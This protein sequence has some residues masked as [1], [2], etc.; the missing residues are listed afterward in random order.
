MRKPC[1]GPEEKVRLSM[2]IGMC[3]LHPQ[4]LVFGQVWA[5]H[6]LGSDEKALQSMFLLG[7]QDKSRK[8]GSL[9]AGSCC[10]TPV[11]SRSMF[12]QE[13]ALQTERPGTR[14]Q[15]CWGQGQEVK[16]AGFGTAQMNLLAGVLGQEGASLSRFWWDRSIVLVSIWAWEDTESPSKYQ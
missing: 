16:G 6:Y 5:H 9:C 12:W 8:A 11:T 4:L 1:L 13:I 7:R 3:N 15:M 2:I 10:S 14:A